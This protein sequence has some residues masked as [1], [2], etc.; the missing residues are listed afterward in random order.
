MQV[1]ET[2]YLSNIFEA[3]PPGGALF[4]ISEA[5]QDFYQH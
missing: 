5:D 1:Q 3:L 4:F 2:K